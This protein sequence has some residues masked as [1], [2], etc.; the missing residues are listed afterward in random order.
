MKAEYRKRTQY[1]KD[2]EY[3]KNKRNLKEWDQIYFQNDIR[4]VIWYKTK[5]W[6][7]VKSVLNG[8]LK[9]IST[10]DNHYK[11]NNHCVRFRK[12]WSILKV[13]TNEQIKKEKELEEEKAVNLSL[14]E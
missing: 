12:L 5:K 2:H 8:V 6:Y 3:K 4:E 11:P 7:T 14:F 10:S 9:Q 1:A 13:K